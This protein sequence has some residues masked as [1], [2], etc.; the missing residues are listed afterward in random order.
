MK[1]ITRLFKRSLQTDLATATANISTWPIKCSF[2]SPCHFSNKI[3]GTWQPKTLAGSAP[4][5]KTPPYHRYFI[6]LIRLVGPVRVHQDRRPVRMQWN[7]FWFVVHEPGPQEFECFS[8]IR[9]NANTL[10]GV[11]DP[12]LWCQPLQV[13]QLGPPTARQQTATFPAQKEVGW[14]SPSHFP[15]WH[16]WPSRPPSAWTP[17]CC[18]STCHYQPRCI[19]PWPPGFPPS[20]KRFQLVFCEADQ[21]FSTFPFPQ[22]SK[23]FKCHSTSSVHSRR[24]SSPKQA[25]IRRLLWPRSSW[26]SCWNSGPMSSLQTACS[27]WCSAKS[28]CQ[29]CVSSSPLLCLCLVHVYQI[30]CKH[31]SN[32]QCLFHTWC[33]RS[34]NLH[35][36]CHSKPFGSSKECRPPLSEV[37][38]CK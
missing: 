36:S 11:G 24:N 37:T 12:K 10:F 20:E 3:P 29:T 4:S 5:N 27:S 30:V 17:S 35:A 13:F 8:R 25:A 28:R 21:A 31:L 33:C 15:R 26:L 1:S 7:R 16:L 6:M 23:K 2:P 9:I 18:V 32:Q 22:P 19:P 14:A 38:P 34:S